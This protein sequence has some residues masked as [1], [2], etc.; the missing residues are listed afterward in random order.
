MSEKPQH[1]PNGGT[2]GS[3]YAFL[4]RLLRRAVVRAVWFVVYVLLAF[5][6]LAVYAS[7]HNAGF[8]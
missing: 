7:L 1:G 6:V 4:L 2:S 8:L 3:R 5:I